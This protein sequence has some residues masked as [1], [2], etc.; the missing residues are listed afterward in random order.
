M[1]KYQITISSHQNKNIIKT[2]YFATC[3][4]KGYLMDILYPLTTY[5]ISIE[6]VEKCPNIILSLDGLLE[7]FL[8]LKL[9]TKVAKNVMEVTKGN[10][11]DFIKKPN[12]ELNVWHGDS[13]ETRTYV[14]NMSFS[15]IER[16]FPETFELDRKSYKPYFKGELELI[17]LENKV[18]RL[19]FTTVKHKVVYEEITLES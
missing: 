3:L 8:T 5:S 10:I 7:T 14:N 15:Q 18:W 1:K 12:F 19:C 6:E 9:K 16:V 13:G 17:Q 2:F 11:S 4:S